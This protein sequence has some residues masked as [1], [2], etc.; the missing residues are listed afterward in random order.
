[1]LSQ[2]TNTKAIALAL[3]L[4]GVSTSGQEVNLAWDR[5]QSHT[6]LSAFILKWGPASGTYP[7][8]INVPTNLTTATV[9]PLTWGST[10][11]FVVTAKNVADL[12][13]DP[14][15]EVSYTVP[16][17]PAAPVLSIDTTLL[18]AINFVLKGTPGYQ[19]VIEEA[20][21]VDA[22]DW[23]ELVRAYVPPSGEVRYAD[24][25]NGLPGQR[26]FRARVLPPP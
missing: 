25:S 20:A 19:I 17:L 6:N 11:F 12:E 8:Q 15:N 23:T 16:L 24:T 14:S 22:R 5:A 3:A 26:F 7:N 2:N 1:M 4:T 21:T 9:G 10:Y 13:S 18:P